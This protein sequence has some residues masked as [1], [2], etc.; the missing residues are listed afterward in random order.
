MIHTENIFSSLKGQRSFSRG[1]R[2]RS[3]KIKPFEMLHLAVIRNFDIRKFDIRKFPE[4]GNSSA[5]F[6]IHVPTP[7]PLDWFTLIIFTVN[8]ELAPTLHVF[9]LPIVECNSS[10][11]FD[12]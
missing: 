9:K 2:G 12:T 8:H 3:S 10:A 1:G 5:L 11:L 7:H 6:Y 4:Y